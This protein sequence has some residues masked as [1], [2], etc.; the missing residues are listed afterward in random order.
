L[1]IAYL[2]ENVTLSPNVTI[3]AA[4]PD[5]I[6]KAR[7]FQAGLRGTP[8]VNNVS[9]AAFLR[10]SDESEVRASRDVSRLLGSVKDSDI[11]VVDDVVDTGATLANLCHRLKLAGARKVYICAAH[12]M[13]TENSMEMIRLSPVERVI[14]TDS[15]PLPPNAD[16]KIVQVSVAPLLARIIE[17]EYFASITSRTEDEEIY[18]SE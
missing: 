4:S 7:R 9:L 1:A 16:Q 3:V 2:R 6:K 13:F 14:V 17:S 12:G 8:G 5:F 18:E 11:I 10:K 15:L